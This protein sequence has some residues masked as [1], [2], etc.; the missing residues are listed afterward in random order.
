MFYTSSRPELSRFRRKLNHELAAWRRMSGLGIGTVLP[1][2]ALA[3]V[4]AADRTG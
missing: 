3:P 4:A 1:V 2:L